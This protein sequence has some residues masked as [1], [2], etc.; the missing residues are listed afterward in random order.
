[1]ANICLTNNADSKAE[2]NLYIANDPLTPMYTGL[3]QI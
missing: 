1:M 3:P 2:Q